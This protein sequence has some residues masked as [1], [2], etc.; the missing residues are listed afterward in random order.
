[1]KS[2]VLF[3]WLR[4]EILFFEDD[5]KAWW[6]IPAILGLISWLLYQV[7]VRGQSE[8]VITTDRLNKSYD[9]I[10]VGAGTAGCVLA[11][12]LSEDPKASVLLLEA[13]GNDIGN[14]IFD[15]PGYTDQAVRTH[16]D[17]KFF[18]V[19]QT[20]AALGWKEQR[21]YWP[22]GRTLGGTSTINSLIYMRGGRGDYDKWAELGAKGWD[23][24]NVLPYF[25][26]SEGLQESDHRN[27]IYHNTAGP[28]LVS[29]LSMT[30][31]AKM[32]LDAGKEMGYKV[33]DCNGNDGEPEGFCKLQSFTGNGLRSSTARG[34]LISA[35]KRP[36]LHIAPNS[37]VTKILFTG[38]S[39]NGVQLVRNGL[40]ETIKAK[41]EV[42][43]SAGAVSSPQILMLSG[44][45]PKEHL[46]KLE[47]P[48]VA[49]LPVGKNLQDHLMIPLM[50]EMNDS[51]SSSPN[52]VFSTWSHIQ[53]KLFKTGYLAMPGMR[54]A[55]AF[56]KLY[57]DSTAPDV[58]MTLHSTDI[59]YSRRFSF[60]E[61]HDEEAKE[62]MENTEEEMKVEG[63]RFTIG[64][65]AP[66]HPHSVG[67]ITLASRD[68]FD[69]PL[70]DPQYLTEKADI[71]I[72][73]RGVRKAQNII[74]TSPFKM[75]SA[76]VVDVEIDQCKTHKFDS[77][78]YW[79]CLVR[80]LALTNYHPSCTCKMGAAEDKTAVV[81]PELRVRGLKKLRVVDASI[82]PFVTACNTN[83]PVIMIAEKAS[84]LIR[85]IKTVKPISKNKNRT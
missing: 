31:L 7:Y 35:S 34:Y 60:L 15:V 62:E 78:P 44:V 9:Y 77:D 2:L 72:F 46:Q 25:I 76:K 19:P 43:I 85:G 18:T 65:M 41:K 27:S 20:H 47:I 6:R 32:F 38:K 56:F 24:D 73:I 23:Y 36:N 67:T 64:V 39:A 79:E 13:G 37:H 69:Y 14:H 29:E 80:H 21:G 45:G 63:R 61:L 71:D 74:A 42:I 16:A 59:T 17:W 22:R 53:Y 33:H 66:Q 48:V 84:D 10:V 4:T 55:G 8:K 40:K 83:A 50:V 49:D 5:S 82:M 26:K 11:N 28:I 75:F 12:R 57:E 3:E 58:Q 51:I 1:M 52:W 70:I 54:E 30:P 68:P 81:D